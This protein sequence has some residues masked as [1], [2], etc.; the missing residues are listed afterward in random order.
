MKIL[1]LS[2]LL[3]LILAPLT[4]FGEGKTSLRLI[5][6]SNIAGEILPCG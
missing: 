4:A 6:G 3:C 2:L 5:Y 1:S